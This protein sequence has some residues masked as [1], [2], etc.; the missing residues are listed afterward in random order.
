NND[1]PAR[2]GMGSSSSFT[3]G[4]LH[5]L[6]ALLGKMPGRQQLASE[7]T[8]VEQERLGETVGCQDQILAAHGGLRQGV[9]H[10]DCPVSPLPLTIDRSRVEAL[11]SHLMLFYTGIARTSSDVAKT[12]VTDL[13]TKRR[14]MRLMRDL[15]EE[16]SAILTGEGELNVFG[17][18]LHE[19]WEAKR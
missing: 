11:Q 2:S 18:L 12:Y 16:G 8:F 10:H 3:V 1:L 17:E 5:A 19:A 9:F 6:Y 13:T 14:Q 4:L 15:V 7:A